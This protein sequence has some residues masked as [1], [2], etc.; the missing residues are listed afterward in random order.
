MRVRTGL[1]ECREIYKPSSSLYKVGEKG[2]AGLGLLSVI[3]ELSFVFI[4]FP[5]MQ[6]RITKKLGPLFRLTCNRKN[7]E[8][9]RKGGTKYRGNFDNSRDNRG[10]AY[11]SNIKSS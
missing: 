6:A 7:R 10:P 2:L 5:R 4:Q 11:L 8:R 9:F 1:G 3:R